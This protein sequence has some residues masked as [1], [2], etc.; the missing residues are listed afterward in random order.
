MRTFDVVVLGAGSA[1]EYV[2]GD[3]A[4][5]G[6]SV[7]LVEALR[8][9]GECPFVA[10]MP[11][12][13]LLRAAAARHLVK[14]AADLDACSVAPVLDDDESA[15]AAAIARRDRVN[16]GG[17]D[18][19]NASALEA[20]GVTLVRGWGEVRGV[21]VVVVGGDEYGYRDLVLATGSTARWPPIEGLADVPTWT[22]DQ[23]LLSPERP[24]SLVVLGGGPVGCELSQV[25]ARFGVEVTLVDDAGRLVPREEPG[26]TDLLAEVLKA[27]GVELVL[28]SRV[29]RAALVEGRARLT[30]SSGSTLDADR[31]LVCTGRRPT[32]EGI[33]LERLGIEPGAGGIEIGPDCRVV[34]HDRVWAAGDVTGIAPFTHTANYQARIVISNLL[35]RPAEAD[36]RA[37]PRAVYT[38]PP[39]ASVGMGEAE[40]RKQ[41]IDAV[42]ATMDVAQTA[43]AAADGDHLGLLVLTADRGR[44]VLV[45]AAAIGPHADEWMAEAVLAIRAEVPVAVL[46]DVVHA[47]PTFSEAMEPPLRG[48]AGKL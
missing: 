39:V 20:R 44:G 47:F 43:R 45:G 27:D 8:V 17:D 1:G 9:G 37:I 6:R 18:S 19:G 29:E 36:Y 14:R 28:G 26:V 34:G 16:H 21:G 24:A 15:F 12:K 13:A 40:A 38:D 5:A 22:S 33:G 32:V 7:A 42:T 41:G 25:Y 10:C 4:D 11:S 2:A 46:A 23:A 48:L 3:L 35:G 30:L 31:V